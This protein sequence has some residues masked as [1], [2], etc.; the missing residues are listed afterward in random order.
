MKKWII[1]GIILLVI[2]IVSVYFYKKSKE[3]PS[4]NTVSIDN[5]AVE[6][7][8]IKSSTSS[9]MKPGD[10]FFQKKM[11][12]DGKYYYEKICMNK[13]GDLYTA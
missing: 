5:S 3:K 8:R 7:S 13:G 1:I 2:L 4:L 11:G 6:N 9:K 12:F 10:C